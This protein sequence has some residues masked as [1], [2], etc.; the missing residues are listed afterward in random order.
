V[1]TDAAHAQRLL[2][3]FAQGRPTHPPSDD[4]PGFDD[5]RAYAVAA[6][7]QARRVAGGETPVGRKLGF[8]NPML[9]ARYGV[10]VPISGAIY[11]STVEWSE[12]RARLAIGHLMQPKIEPEIQLH[13]TARPP[14][15]ADE[16][17]ILACVDWIAHGFE[18][19]RC[20][21]PEWR[22]TS[23]DAIA[24]GA[25]HAALVLGPPLAVCDP[26]GLAERLRTFTLV[27]SGS[28]GQLETGGGADVLGSPVLAAAALDPPPG[29]GEIVTT[30]SLT[31]ALGVAPGETWST[32]IEGLDLPGMTIDL[33]D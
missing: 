33:V 29:A 15:G 4:E 9:M 23:A 25:L 31:A 6:E 12:G 11:D 5:R 27:L 18:F 21:Y 16:A 32:R 20:P 1:G 8:T 13:F 2:E 30:G 22:F 7:L 10:N 24:C 19:V 3:A 28:G 26:A 17:T 14:D